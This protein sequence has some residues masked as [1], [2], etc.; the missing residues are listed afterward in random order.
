MAPFEDTGLRVNTSEERDIYA[1]RKQYQ[2]KSV[3]R[4]QVTHLA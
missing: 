3:E 2:K 4:Y 1:F